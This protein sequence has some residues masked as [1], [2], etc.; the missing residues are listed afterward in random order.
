MAS[1]GKWNANNTFGTHLDQVKPSCHP[2]PIQ[3][4]PNFAFLLD[5]FPVIISNLHAI[6]SLADSRKAC[7][8]LSIV[9]GE[10][11]HSMCAIKLTH[12]LFVIRV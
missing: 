5:D 2:L 4:D 12:M 10:G 9:V 6:E 11:M 8:T 7:D 3:W 1:D